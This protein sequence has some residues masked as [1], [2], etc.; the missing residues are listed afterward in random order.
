MFK[1][2]IKIE[3]PKSTLEIV[4]MILKFNEQNKQGKGL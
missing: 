3:K 2:E 1:E 4:E